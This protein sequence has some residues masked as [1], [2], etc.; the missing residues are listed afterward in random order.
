MIYKYISTLKTKV[1]YWS[2]TKAKDHPKFINIEGQ[3]IE[4]SKSVKY[5]GIIIDNK[6]NWNEHIQE[7]VKKYKKALFAAKRAID[8][9]WGLSPKQMIWIYLQIYQTKLRISMLWIKINFVVLT[10]LV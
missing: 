1:V 5:L 2:K 9:K 7:T 8:N 3:K 4:I 10:I 6:L